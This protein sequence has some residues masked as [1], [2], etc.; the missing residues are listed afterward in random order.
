MSCRRERP[1][2][3]ALSVVGGWFSGWGTQQVHKGG[4]RFGVTAGPERPETRAAWSRSPSTWEARTLGLA[5]IVLRFFHQRIQKPQ[6]N[7]LANPIWVILSK[8]HRFVLLT[9]NHMGYWKEE[10]G[11]TNFQ[12]IRGR[13][14]GPSYCPEPCLLLHPWPELTIR[15]HAP[16]RPT[17]LYWTS[18]V[19][20]MCGSH[21][22]GCHSVVPDSLRPHGL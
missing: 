2:T 15:A 20:H 9:H 16:D 4:K 10:R 11:E 14:D 21:T 19:A 1:P 12:N 3:C 6:T 13:A 8:Q 7:V 22:C 5:R 18:L 17:F